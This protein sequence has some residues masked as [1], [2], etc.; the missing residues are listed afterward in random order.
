MVAQKISLRFFYFGLQY[1]DECDGGSAY[2]DLVG[3]FGIGAGRV[4][5]GDDNTEGDEREVEDG[6][7]EGVGGENE[8]ALSVGKAELG[9][10]RGGKGSDSKNEL[11]VENMV[12]GGC[13][14]EGRGGECWKREMR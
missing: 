10:K 2:A 4:G 14:E 7:V 5:R 1:C 11:G 8:D 9:L 12:S 13:I 3:N 6:E